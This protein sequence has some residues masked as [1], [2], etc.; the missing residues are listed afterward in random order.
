M[1][2]A[3]SL[4]A[5]CENAVAHGSTVQEMARTVMLGHADATIIW[6][7]TARQGDFAKTLTTIAI[8]GA[9]TVRIVICRVSDTPRAEL[10]DAFIDYVRTGD[11]SRAAFTKYGFTVAAPTTAPAP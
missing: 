4:A 1:L 8:P 11:S 5:V 9:P 3:A 2:R 6:D 10:A 7:A